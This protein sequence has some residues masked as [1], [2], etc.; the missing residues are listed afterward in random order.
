M[1][2]LGGHCIESI[3]E[4]FDGATGDIPTLFIAYTVKGYGLPFAG[5][6]DNHAGLM[7]PTQIEELRAHPVMN[8]GHGL[9]WGIICGQPPLP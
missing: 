4:A 5:H 9:G 6:K 2:N 1:T 7:T 8:G 3:C